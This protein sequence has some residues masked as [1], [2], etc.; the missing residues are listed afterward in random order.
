MSVHYLHTKIRVSDL[1]RAI[2]FYQM[3]FGYTLRKRK[4]GPDSSLLAFLALPG[5]ETELQLAFYPDQGAFEVPAYLM[6]LAFR[7]EQLQKVV[8]SALEAGATLI[9][10]AYTL[11]S[12]SKVAFIRDLDGY[13]IEVIEK[14]H[15]AS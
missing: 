5:E 7:V 13:E 12:G 11:P 9:R 15:S 4:P 3:A 1:E 2:A 6:H 10:D 14:P 8:E